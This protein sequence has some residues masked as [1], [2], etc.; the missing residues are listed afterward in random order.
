MEKSRDQALLA[1]SNVLNPV[2]P[3]LPYVTCNYTRHLL[4]DQG[5]LLSL[6]RLTIS[7]SIKG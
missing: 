5:A 6:V 1:I 3:V 4:N 2:L 7:L